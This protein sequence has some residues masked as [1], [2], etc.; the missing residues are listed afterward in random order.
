MYRQRMIKTATGFSLVQRLLGLEIVIP[1][2]V[3]TKRTRRGLEVGHEVDEGRA[4]LV[5]MPGG[6]VRVLTV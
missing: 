6:R 1:L 4:I 5:N 2:R 3:T